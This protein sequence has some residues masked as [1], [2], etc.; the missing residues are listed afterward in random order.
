M[1]AFHSDMMAADLG[2]I[3]A[4]KLRD[5]YAGFVRGRGYLNGRHFFRVYAFEMFLRRF[6]K[7]GF[8]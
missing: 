2:L 3:E 4:G 1:G 8:A 7:N 5:M 6:L